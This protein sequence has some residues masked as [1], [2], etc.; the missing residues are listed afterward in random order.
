MKGRARERNV[1]WDTGLSPEARALVEDCLKTIA[2]QDWPQRR[3]TIE[4][5]LAASLPKDTE[6]AAHAGRA[7]QMTGAVVAAI[8]E[9]LGCP[10]IVDAEQALFQ[11]LA[12]IAGF[13]EPAAPGA[14]TGLDA[15]SQDLERVPLAQPGGPSTR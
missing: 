2:T 6:A 12:D 4:I 15:A 13:F 8:I 5:T 3:R 14:E 9:R 11:K 7:A 10:P 1:D